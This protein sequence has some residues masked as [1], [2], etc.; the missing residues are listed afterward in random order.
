MQIK[1]LSGL[2]QGLA[3]R[4][5][6]PHEASVSTMKKRVAMNRGAKEPAGRAHLGEMKGQ[7]DRLEH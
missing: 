7:A 2:P 5:Q 3:S 4:P 1:D 6:R